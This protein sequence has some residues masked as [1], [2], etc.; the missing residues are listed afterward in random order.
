M[1]AVQI[2][3]QTVKIGMLSLHYAIK[4]NWY[5]PIVNKMS[6]QH[7]PE[8][9]EISITINGESRQFPQPLSCAALIALLGLAGKR[10][11]LECNGEIVP[12]GHHGEHTLA[13]GDRIEI[14][15]AV[16]GG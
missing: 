15:A 10:V 13:D 8:D 4:I 2:L 16:G 5:I 6:I 3:C 12:R 11:A 1:N 14:V 9:P 7:C